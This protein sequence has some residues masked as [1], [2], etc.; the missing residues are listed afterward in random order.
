MR[1]A[2]S[3]LLIP[4]FMLSLKASTFPHGVWSCMGGLVLCLVLV[5]NSDPIP[6]VWFWCLVHCLVFVSGPGK[7]SSVSGSV[8]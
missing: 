1:C 6:G 4:R 2:F 8:V 5:S 3:A 7:S